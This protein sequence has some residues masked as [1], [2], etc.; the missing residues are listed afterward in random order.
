MSALQRMK[1]AL[2]KWLVLF[3]LFPFSLT[4][5]NAHTDVKGMVR[6]EQGRALPGVSV[7]AKKADTAFS[8]TAESKPDG[9]FSFSQLPSGN[10]VFTLS[11]VGY[12]TQTL[13]G[14]ELKPGATASLV[15]K[16]QQKERALSEVVV[17][18]YGTQ[19]KEE[20]TSAV[21]SVKAKDFVKGSVNDAS[22]LIRGKVAGL[23]II[24]PDAN[25]TGTSQIL[26]R[27]LNSIS[28]AGANP[29][30]LV[31]G[32]PGSLTT[33]APEDI[34]RI[35]VLKD[36]SAA[37]IYGT[38]GTN[39]VILI[40]TKKVNGELP[41]TVE[42]NSYAT[43]QSIARK[44]D[45]FSA[46]AYR[47]LVAQ[48][49]PGAMDYGANTNWLDEITQTPVS[50][51]YSI[52]LKAGNKNTNYIASFE[53]RSLNGI[54]KKTDNK[55]FY[56]RFEINHNMFNGKLK[57][58]GN[59]SGYQQSYFAGADGG[60][61][62]GDI[63]RNA[64]TYNPTDPVKAPD[65]TWTQHTDK[66][67]Y[68]NPVSLLEET[69]GEN[70]YTDFR[71][72]GSL[73]FLPVNGLTFKLLGSHDEQHSTRGYY[74]TK[75]HISTVRDGKNGYASRGTTRSTDD[76]VEATAQYSG[77]W[78]AHNLTGLAGYSWRKQYSEN[79]YM[80]NWDFP[81][82]FFTY[83]NMGAGKALS[84]GEAVEYSYAE[85]STLL[86]YFLR[87]NYNF[88]ER[89]LLS[90]S[91]RRE[92]SSRFGA[93]HKY[94][95]FPAVSVGWNIQK[96][97]FMRNVNFLS[98]LKIRAGYGITGTEPSGPYKSLNTIDFNSF[99]YINGEWIQVI[100]PSKNP[101][102][103]LRWEKKKEGNLGLDF[104]LWKDRLT[105]SVDVYKRTVDD[106]ILDYNVPTP[107]YLFPTITANAATMQNK[108]I[109]VTLN[110]VPVQG[111]HFSWFTSVN[112]ST[113]SN[114]VVSLSND[115]FSVKA[116]YFDQ[117][118]TGEPIQTIT[119]R[120][121]IGQPV[122]NFWGYKSVDIDDNGHWI[123]Q[124]Q[125][126]KPKPI[127]QQQPNDKTILGNGLPK[128]YLN[129][130]NTITCKNFDLN[131]TMR[132][133]FGFSI[134][135]MAQMFYGVPV[136]LTRGNLLTSAY[137]N[138]YGKR[139][140]ADDQELQ[141]VSYFVQKGDYWKIDNITLGYHFDLHS[142]HI[143]GL[144]LYVSG[145]NLFT[146]TGYKGID[147][148]VSISGLAPGVDDRNRYPSTRT[149]TLGANISF[150]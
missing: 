47:Q 80:Q 42:L 116:G 142:E 140:L 87:L 66:T 23:N 111:K 145:S 41:P 14:Y 44:L 99:A 21:S 132:G 110:G 119:H 117:G 76:L 8:A 125:D 33:V 100:S 70:K 106:L 104:G 91:I 90:A 115:K 146:I 1:N 38:R 9:V 84:R 114:K 7:T 102:P 77:S 27:G 144:R 101:N 139:P 18:G 48:Q 71:T 43:I 143:R 108:G 31:D 130:N 57:F 56:P 39:G 35:D 22:Q 28:N 13:S 68:V 19:R 83:N 148:E 61:Y 124:G 129:W 74:E 29:L 40:T 92:G 15:V 78:G 85:K 6:D 52:N 20:L 62:R 45:V 133:A 95:N 126:G 134:L 59:V 3:L 122:G 17:V 123:I 109:E 149:F 127:A 26:L 96:E 25:P 49:K 112:Y 51:V 11:L 118:A 67:D 34:D 36:G 136:M 58:N 137:N 12:E 141:Y 86:S 82:D 131:V 24:T 120:V 53:Y 64:V 2:T 79:Y 128:Q 63:Y 107:P 103:D 121:Q 81:S 147:P 32:I 65:G 54:I 73:S 98:S 37:A 105:G 94:G 60:S 30:I 97:N 75:Q 50:Q 135:N 5:Q 89:Y 150:Q 55:F 88:K 10:Y 69:K 16:L 138:V 113:N 72:F 46:N 4:A 93:N